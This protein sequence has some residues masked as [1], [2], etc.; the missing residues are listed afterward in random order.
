MSLLYL[1]VDED[2]DWQ[3][4]QQINQ[5]VHDKQFLETMN[6]MFLHLAGL[7]SLSLLLFHSCRSSLRCATDSTTAIQDSS[8]MSP[9]PPM[10]YS[11]STTPS[12]PLWRPGEKIGSSA[13]TTSLMTNT[14][15]NVHCLSTQRNDSTALCEEVCR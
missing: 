11:K 13:R 1:L 2:F 3:L 6:R 7:C 4:P 10:M 14:T 15:C 8:P 5:E 9:K 12:M